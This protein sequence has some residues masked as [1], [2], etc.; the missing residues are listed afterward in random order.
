MQPRAPI[1]VSRSRARFLWERV[2]ERFWT[3]VLRRTRVGQEFD[4][5]VRPGDLV[6]NI[7][8]ANGLFERREIQALQH[9][10]QL[11]RSKDPHSKAGVFL[12]VG[13]NIGAYSVALSSWFAEVIAFEPN[14][15]VAN[16][17]RANLAQNRCP[18]VKVVEKALGA[19][20]A[21]ATLYSIE[22]WNIGMA[23]LIPAEGAEEI[24]SV[25]V[26][27]GDDLLA[28]LVQQGVRVELL[29]IDVEGHEPHALQGLMS[30]LTAH[31]PLIAFEVRGADVA[32]EVTRILTSAGYR[33]FYWVER[34]KR[35]AIMGRLGR[36]LELIWLGANI[37]LT[38]IET[39]SD[40]FY[41]MVLATA[42]PIDC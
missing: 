20:P 1:L 27:R 8:I 26:V 23:S 6:G 37:Q 35:R 33:Y 12:D 28:D 21:R 2:S 34:P 4:F 14:P 42:A 38:P 40:T 30:T 13:A 15:I 9:I 29:K 31:Q 22:K 24:A 39:F 36:V 10:V 41:S 19:E 17:L 25:D 32:K 7:T 3:A 5:Y 16:I 11:A 18:N